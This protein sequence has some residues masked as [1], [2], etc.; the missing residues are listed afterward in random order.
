[1]PLMNAIGAIYQIRDDILNL[2]ASEYTKNEGFCKDITEGK[3]SFPIVHSINSDPKNMQ[4]MNILRQRS[5]DITLKAYVVDY[6]TS[7]QSFTYS[8]TKLN[9]LIVE[10]KSMVDE[11]DAQIGPST[12]ISAFLETL[13]LD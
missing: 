10:A 11:L 12:G 8:Y 5:D 13:K 1:M 2:K 3:F 4:L 7:M 6:I 9:L